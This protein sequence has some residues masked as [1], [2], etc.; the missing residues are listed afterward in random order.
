[1]KI[2]TE[3]W[4]IGAGALALVAGL[5]ALGQDTPESLL[6][7]GFED[8]AAP[9]A[10]APSPRPGATPGTTTGTAV[11]PPPVVPALPGAPAALPTPIA[12][13][14]P[15]PVDPEALRDYELPAFARRGLDAVGVAGSGYGGQA[16]GTARGRFQEQ[17]M[18]RLDAPVAS[19]WLSIALR[20]ALAAEVVTPGDV[21]GADFAA[22]RAWLLLRMGE[23]P[24]ARALVQG[25]D[26]ENYT[27]KL[28]QVAMQAMLATGDPAGL[29]PLVDGA[30]RVSDEAGWTLARGMCLGL[31][32]DP[33]GAGPIID[34][35]RRRVRT[36]QLFDVLL[37]EKVV[38]AGAGGRRAVTVE[39]DGVDQLSAWRY[40]LAIA[41][42]VEVPA[43]LFDTVRP[44]VRYWH[45]LA[46]GVAPGVRLPF[47]E[48]A[49]VQGVL[50]ADALADLYGT[51]G[52]D[53]DASSAQTALAAD[54]ATAFTAGRQDERLAM[55]RRLWSQPEAEAD[56][57]ARQ[58]LTARASALLTPDAA[59]VADAD[60]L[61]AS[62]LS[63]GLDLPALRWAPL[64]PAGS[65]AW[66][67]LA[68]ATPRGR[69]VDPGAVAD[70]DGGG[71][72]AQLLFAGLAGL[73]RIAAGEV[74][75]AARD[76]DVAV[77]RRNG[78]TIAIDAAALRGDA[79]TVLL[80]AAVGMQT[81]D[82]R[83]V[84]P[85][86]LFHIVAALRAAGLE[87]EAR[88]IAAE[89]IARG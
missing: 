36:G 81:R 39:W 79:G 8:P 17:L 26:A 35:A 62:M 33:S 66:A 64:V 89:A 59:G 22:E 32:G 20:R 12:S 68:V 87:G 51:L 60:A 80:L 77:G 25:V 1:M 88:M 86:A 3:R 42:G 27:P 29:C 5:P 24:V 38:G 37:A 6:P 55:L 76:L 52:E 70:F 44:Q 31:A 23:A 57:Y 7:P 75:G 48:A 49:A 65:P 40:G 18:R 16:F 46:P 43:A 67:M 47:A 83:G 13:A 28:F 4:L 58:L 10:P 15:E 54:L 50:S 82:W 45:A 21:N 61:V 74:E 34:R 73:N 9:P 19:R 41:T 72:R 78:W 71:R 14:T 69:L 63:A 53:E 84:S 2:S 11:P 56:R 30:L 85:E